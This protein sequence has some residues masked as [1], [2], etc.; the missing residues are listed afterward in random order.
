MKRFWL[1]NTVM[2][3][4][5]CLVAGSALAATS[6][7]PAAGDWLCSGKRSL[8]ASVKGAGS[9]TMSGSLAEAPLNLSA[10]GSFDTDGEFH[11]TWEQNKNK[12]ILHVDPV[13]LAADLEDLIYETVEAYVDVTIKGTSMKATIAKDG[14]HLTGLSFKFKFAVEYDGKTGSGTYSVSGKAVRSPFGAPRKESLNGTGGTLVKP[15]AD[16]IIKEMLPDLM[17]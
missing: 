12:V 4:F 14:A 1:V 2:V 7:P 3:M 15:L 5:F 11:G 8:K 16:M 13:D 9:K 17:R 10:D 6:Y